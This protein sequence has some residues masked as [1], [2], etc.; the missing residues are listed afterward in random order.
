MYLWL[1]GRAD[2]RNTTEE[3]SPPPESARERSCAPDPRFRLGLGFKQCGLHLRIFYPDGHTLDHFTF[4]R[5]VQRCSVHRSLSGVAP[6]LG[7]ANAGGYRSCQHF[8]LFRALLLSAYAAHSVSWGGSL[9][10]AGP[11][12]GPQ[13]PPIAVATQERRLLAVA[14]RPMLGWIAPTSLLAPWVCPL[15]PVPRPLS[16]PLPM[17]I[18]VSHPPGRGVSGG[19]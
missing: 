11:N 4:D 12:A 14:C 16:V 2:W 9:A 7:T 5:L 1:L 15:M 6:L 18:G 13:A 19:W 17:P 8:W 10:P 3:Y